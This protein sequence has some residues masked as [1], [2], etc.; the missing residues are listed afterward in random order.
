MARVRRG[1][2]LSV[3]CPNCGYEFKQP[4][5]WFQTND[6]YFC[7]G[8]GC[9]MLVALDLQE[10]RQKIAVGARD[11]GESFKNIR[12]AAYRGKRT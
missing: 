1:R 3:P 6:S 2:I 8:D 4:V 9:G 10:L 7:A 12:A 11:L 5:A